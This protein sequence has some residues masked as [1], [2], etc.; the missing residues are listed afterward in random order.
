M[1]IVPSLAESM[2]VL[3]VIS[4]YH[5]SQEKKNTH[6]ER[7]NLLKMSNGSFKMNQ[8]IAEQIDMLVELMPNE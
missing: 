3:F 7:D 2:R 6:L 4:E 1:K 5:T 8:E